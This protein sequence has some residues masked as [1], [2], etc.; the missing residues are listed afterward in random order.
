MKKVLTTIISVTCGLASMILFSCEND[1]FPSTGIDGCPSMI[2]IQNEGKTTFAYHDKQL[3]KIKSPSGF[4]IHYEYKNGELTSRSITPPENVADGNGRT[5]FIHEGNKIKVESSGEPSFEL[6]TEEIELDE[7]GYPVK[8]SDTGV[9]QWDEKGLS[10]VSE[11]QHY[12]LFT[13]SSSTRQ[14]TR[15]EIYSLKDSSLLASYTYE[16]DGNP[17]VISHMAHPV[18]H[19]IWTSY[20]DSYSTRFSNLY[21]LSYRNNI[22]QIKVEDKESNLFKTVTFQYTYNSKGFPVQV[23]GSEDEDAEIRY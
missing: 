7:N 13:Y 16:Y 4:T 14:L 18:W 8:I 2:S 17:G 20:R 5:N 21:F 23:S 10:P 9:F 3:A 15:Q 1:E 6:Y 12:A 11:G 22:T 19:A